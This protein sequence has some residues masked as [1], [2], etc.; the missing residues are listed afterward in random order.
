MVSFVRYSI[1]D[2]GAEHHLTATHEI[3][4]HVIQARLK[5][6]QINI[7]EVNFVVSCNLNPDISFDVVDESSNINAIKLCPFL[8]VFSVR[9]VLVFNDFKKQ[10]LTGASDDKS[11]VVKKIHLSQILVSHLLE[12]VIIGVICLDRK[13]LS[14]SVEA[15]NHVFF[16]VV[17]TLVREVHHVALHVYFLESSIDQSMLFVIVYEVVVH[18]AVVVKELD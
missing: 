4:H 16:R 6:L 17:K 11:L 9:V 8:V 7:I 5:S 1:L 14:L 10:H 12:S 13:C 2:F 15:I 3:V 18:L